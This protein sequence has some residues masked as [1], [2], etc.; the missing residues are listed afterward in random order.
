MPADH[1]EFNSLFEQTLAA[2]NEMLR[3]KVELKKAQ[4][5]YGASKK[6]AKAKLR[7][8]QESDL[9]ENSQAPSWPEDYHF[10]NNNNN[11]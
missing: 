10:V 6:Q 5:E 2:N 11:Q 4:S 7:S 9:N 3:I 8:S 1:P